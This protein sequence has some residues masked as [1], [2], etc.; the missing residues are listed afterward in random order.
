MCTNP[1]LLFSVHSGVPAFRSQT[2]TVPSSYP[3]HARF[4]GKVGEVNST[5]L[6]GTHRII[7]LANPV[8]K[9]VMNLLMRSVTVTKCP[10]P[11]LLT[12][13]LDQILNPRK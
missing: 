6:A 7:R 5:L 12:V 2:F 8:E 1:D 4:P 11:F 3:I 10:K 13:K 9:T